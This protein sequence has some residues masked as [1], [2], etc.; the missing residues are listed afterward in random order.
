[1]PR[2]SR[3]SCW[4]P[5]ASRWVAPLAPNVSID[6]SPS[7]LAASVGYALLRMLLVFTLT[8]GHVDATHHWT[9]Q[10]LI[11]VFA[12]LQHRPMLSFQPTL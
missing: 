1:V 2:R 10:V 9:E 6:L 5:A 8:D 7:V 3:C 11:P 4:L 12:L